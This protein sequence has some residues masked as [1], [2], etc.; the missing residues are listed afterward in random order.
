MG[1]DT[2]TAIL[3]RQAGAAQCQG[4]TC[5]GHSFFDVFALKLTRWDAIYFTQ[6]AERG[7]VYEQEWAFGWAYTVAVGSLAQG[8]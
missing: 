7:Y 8:L 3:W 2:S 5:K 1:Y 6:I 4:N